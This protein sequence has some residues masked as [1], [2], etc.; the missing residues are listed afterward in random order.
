MYYFVFHKTPF[1]KGLFFLN[2]LFFLLLLTQCKQDPPMVEPEP[3]P[4]S[5]P[6]ITTTGQNTFGCLVNGEVW[7]PE[8]NRPGFL[9][10]LV[11]FYNGMTFNINAVRITEDVDQDIGIGIDTLN[12]ESVYKLTIPNKQIAGVNDIQN[13]CSYDIPFEGELEIIRLDYFKKIISGK[14]WFTHALEECDTIR[15][16]DGRFD[17]AY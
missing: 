6:P 14:F 13:S 1:S 9:P 11:V 10:N 17:V 8:G 15:V 2:L 12:E 16:T 7:L 4:P 3:D 5:L